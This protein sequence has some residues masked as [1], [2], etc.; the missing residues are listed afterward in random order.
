MMAHQQ[1][2]RAPR[3][4]RAE[5][6]R[7]V[8]DTAA[9]LFYA[10]GVHE[11][12]MDELVRET[13]LGKATVYRLFP[14]KDDLVA[15]YLR[16]AAGDILDQID[17]GTERAPDPAT[18]LHAV[19]SSV[20]ADLARPDFRGCAFNNASIEYADPQHPARVAARDYRLALHD[21][22]HRLAVRIMPEQRDEAAAL[23]G[24]LATLVD[25]AYTSAAHLGPAGPAAAGMALAHHLVDRVTT[26]AT[27]TDLR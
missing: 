19:L 15:A 23:A 17:A 12:G 2:Q 6:Q 13:G 22:L 3:R 7:I 24:Q 8:L 11:V 27:S 20:Q 10:R 9:R 4:E 5:R 25:G 21:R 16:R 1:A 14:T 18:A 26:T